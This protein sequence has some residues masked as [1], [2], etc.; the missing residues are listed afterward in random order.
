VGGCPV[1][2]AGPGKSDQYRPRYSQFRAYFHFYISFRF[3][4][5]WSNV[6][7]II[8]F[9]HTFAT[10]VSVLEQGR[11]TVAPLKKLFHTI[12]EDMCFKVGPKFRRVKMVQIWMCWA[13]NAV[14]VGQEQA[15]C[16]PTSL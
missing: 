2:E 4:V 10:S 11:I 13:Y 12:L 5:C 9:A 14:T 8:L 16:E 15:L 7:R 6:I 3:T 1:K